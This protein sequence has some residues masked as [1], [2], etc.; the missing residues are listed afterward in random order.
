MLISGLASVTFRNKSP[1]EIC[2]LC[3]RAQLR[4]VEWGGDVHV[5][6]GNLHRAAEVRRMSLEHGLII[7]SYGSYYRLTKP[8]DEF[9]ACLE[10]ACELGAGTV[11]I[12]C[13]S[14]GSQI[15][16]TDRSRLIDTLLECAQAARSYSLIIAPEYHT[17]TL[18]DERSSVRRLWAET[19]AYDDCLS[20]YWQ[21]RFDRPCAERTA[22]LLEILPRLTH[23]HVFSWMGN[24]GK[25]RLPLNGEERMWR[26]ILSIVHRHTP[27]DK[28]RCALLE[29]VQDDSEASLLRDAACLNGYLKEPECI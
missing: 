12:W 21:P 23:L 22:S 3:Q 11:R 26:E 9:Y 18:T 5:P 27:S 2:A 20:F 24:D 8:L 28:E 14:V 29:F 19:A 7:P 17:R 10:T 6:C 25:H 13:G 1:R 16:E 4:A 15:P